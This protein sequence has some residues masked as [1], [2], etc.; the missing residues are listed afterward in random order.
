M[1]Y[2]HYMYQHTDLS[3]GWNAFCEDLGA[4]IREAALGDIAIAGPS[5]SGEP[6]VTADRIAL[7]GSA[8]QAGGDHESLEIERRKGVDSWRAGA[9]DSFTFCKTAS[10]PYDDVVVALYALAQ[11]R[12]PHGVQVSSDGGPEDWAP[13]LALAERATGRAVPLPPRVAASGAYRDAFPERRCLSQRR[14]NHS[15]NREGACR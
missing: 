3:E 12:W 7:N 15:C 8:Q 10:K 2:T 14:T 6:L 4:V 13:G 1:G 11:Q 9:D 5:G